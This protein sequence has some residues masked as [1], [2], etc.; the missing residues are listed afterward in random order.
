MNKRTLFGMFF[1]SVFFTVV[2][3][4]LMQE[5]PPESADAKVG[6]LL[7]AEL[8]EKV[9]DVASLWV[10]AQEGSFTLRREDGVWGL[11][12]KGGYAVDVA[13]VRKLLL[14]LKDARVA[15]QKTDNPTLYPRLGVEEPDAQDASSK[16]VV[17]LDGAGTELVSLIVGNRR[18]AGSGRSTP[19]PSSGPDSYFVR[20]SGEARAL[21]VE[22]ELDVSV[23]QGDW[24]E[25]AI[26]DISR[27]RIKTVEIRHGDGEV[28]VVR[29]NHPDD[30]NWELPT[31]PEGKQLTYEGAPNSLASGLSS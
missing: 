22:G 29:K 16:R 3:V 10:E 13:G 9:N 23:E 12:E 25:K 27:D 11:E 6:E 15:E 26:L 2:A 14:A 21:L 31:L 7:F 20:R 28:V 17:A 18:S 24:L 30:R 1:A 5:D 19:I 8:A 4:S